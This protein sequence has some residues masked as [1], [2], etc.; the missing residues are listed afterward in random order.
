MTDTISQNDSPPSTATRKKRLVAIVAGVLVV[1]L[2]GALAA[3][4]GPGLV[5]YQGASN[6][7]EPSPSS[8]KPAPTQLTEY[9]NDQAGIALSYPSTWA[10]LRAKDPQVL[11]VASEGTE[12]TFQLRAVQ[13]PTVVNQ[14]QLPAAKQLTD[15]I[16]GANKTA[17]MLTEP[18]QITLGGLPGYWYLYT[19]KDESSG[20]E[21]AHSHFFIFKDKTML[22]FVFESIPS[23]KF[24][25]TAPNFDQIAAS[26]HVLQK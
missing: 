11:L 23:S 7:A 4:F 3:I 22:S 16:V 21:G 19:F 13:L 17:Q 25:D 8:A 20:Q 6:G 12:G 15:Q 18:K 10:Q 26:F 2:L 5:G 9:R 24:K 14:Q 1:I